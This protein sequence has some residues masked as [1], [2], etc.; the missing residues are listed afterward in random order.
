[1]KQPLEELKKSLM[2]IK[3][4]EEKR[5]DYLKEREVKTLK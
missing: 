3:G 4:L 1:M 5:S 2:K